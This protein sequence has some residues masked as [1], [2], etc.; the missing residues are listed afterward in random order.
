MNKYD[1]FH[2]DKAESQN[3]CKV[4]I[5]NIVLSPESGRIMVFYQKAFNLESF[6][7]HGRKFQVADKKLPGGK[8]RH[9]LPRKSDIE[10]PARYPNHILCLCNPS[11]KKKIILP[12]FTSDQ[13]CPIKI[14]VI[15]N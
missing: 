2:D 14:Y 1:I 5:N 13:A 12:N 11:S 8:I 9:P 10:L 15:L 3:Y 4:T 6:N 7:N